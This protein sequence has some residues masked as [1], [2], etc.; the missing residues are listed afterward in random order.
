MASPYTDLDRPPLVP[1]E[2]TAALR[3]DPGATRL[4]REIRVVAETGSTNDDLAAAAVAGE[5]GGLV[6]V[7]EHQVAGRG[8]LQRTWDSP[9]RAGLTFSM[10]LR[11]PVPPSSVPLLPLLV[12]TATATAVTERTDVDVRLKWPNDLMVDDR[13][14]GGLLATVVGGVDE[15]AVVVGLGLN[16]STRRA[17]LARP[18][19]SSLQLEARKPVDRQALLL[20]VLRS[21]AGAYST[22]IALGGT[23]GGVLSRYRKLSATLG[24]SVRVE[25][26]AGEAIT[27]VAVDVDEA[28]RLVVDTADGS[29]V[30]S[31]ADVTHLRPVDRG[32]G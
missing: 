26:S 28:G 4:W 11:P 16:V 1:A 19:A 3:H 15:L 14:L 7:A 8:R 24:R 20:A 12:A 9:P 27:G 21:V 17:E 29:Q 31:A 18:D 6:L 13:K 30:V 2:L 25:L 5:P 23:P 22:W 10:L 32:E